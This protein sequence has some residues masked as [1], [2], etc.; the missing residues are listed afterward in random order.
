[1]DADRIADGLLDASL[2]QPEWTHAG[3]V[4]AAHALVRRL[5]HTGALA[6]F[7]A[8]VPRLNDAHGV[9]NTDTGGYHDTITVFF[10]AAVADAVAR[11]LDAP[12]TAVALPPDAPL[13]YWTRD[14]LFSV[15]ARHGYVAP[16]IAAPAFAVLV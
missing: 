2:P 13:A 3:H 4:A 7:R 15:P 12:E 1:V 9:A 8:A 14:V 6:A 11:G 16:D 10:I 5:G